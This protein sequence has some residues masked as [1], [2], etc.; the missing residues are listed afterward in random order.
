M[1]TQS[2]PVS[3]RPV[4]TPRRAAPWRV[5]AGALVVTAASVT[6]APAPA[7]DAGQWQRLERLETATAAPGAGF[8]EGEPVQVAQLAPSLA[9]DFEVRLQRLERMIAEL[10]GRSDE[11]GYQITQLKERLERI[12]GDVDFRLNQLE[13]GKGGG[14]L[15][16]AAPAAPAART[17]GGA[18]KPVPT[19]KPEAKPDTKSQSAALPAG[20]TP[21]K[22]YEYAFAFLRNQEYDKAE[23]ALQEFIGKHKSNDLAGN[24]QY[25][26][27]ETYYV[28][29][30]YTEAAV[31]FADGMQ[32][33]PKNTKAPDN[34][35]K[36][37]MSLAQLNK[38]AEACTAFGQ[39][40][41]RF[42]NA[43]ASIK[44]RSEAEQRR[45]NCPG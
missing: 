1:N 44:R 39:I 25:W 23:K 13:S 20:A 5:L 33:Y 2:S 11:L 28:Q 15:S 12:N 4:P 3:R 37:G 17:E 29:R 41:K 19:A 40:G 45:L 34:L 26:L 32:K 16:A 35:L 9:A 24:A 31:A 14:G 10:N 21:E 6:A 36:L 43:A 30:K 22:Q 27:G 7:Q 8:A 42:P 18:D 38:K